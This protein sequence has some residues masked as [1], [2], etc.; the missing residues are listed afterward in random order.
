MEDFKFAVGA[1]VDKLDGYSFPG[2]VVARFK[3][4]A[5]KI[6]YVV[7]AKGSNDDF[8]GMLHIFNEDQLYFQM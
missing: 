6:R 3:T 1:I 8:K 7:E 4:T 2:V 5:G